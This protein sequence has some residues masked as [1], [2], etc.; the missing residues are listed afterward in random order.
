[1]Q[2]GIWP[3]PANKAGWTQYRQHPADRIT[4]TSRPD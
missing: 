4:I 3:Q 1:M 2:R